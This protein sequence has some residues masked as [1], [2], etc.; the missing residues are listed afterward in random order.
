[1][2]PSKNSGRSA[3]QGILAPPT[4]SSYKKAQTPPPPSE[5]TGGSA[6]PVQKPM[7]P[8]QSQNALPQAPA[9]NLSA[10][11]TSKV[12]SPH[13]RPA[14]IHPSTTD[15]NAKRPPDS[16][17]KQP[18]PPSKSNPEDAK[19]SSKGLLAKPNESPSPEQGEGSTSQPL[20]RTHSSPPGF[21]DAKQ[22]DSGALQHQGQS[23]SQA[24]GPEAALPPPEDPKVSLADLLEH[25]FKFYDFDAKDHQLV[26]LL[27]N[28]LS[29]D[30]DVAYQSWVVF[31]KKGPV[32][33]HLTN[34]LELNRVSKRGDTAHPVSC[35]L[36]LKKSGIKLSAI[37][38]LREV[39]PD[40]LRPCS[41]LIA[42][43][44]LTAPF[45]DRVAESNFPVELFKDVSSLL[46][47]ECQR[48]ELSVD[49]ERLQAWAVEVI[50]TTWG[51]G[52]SEEKSLE[53]APYT[54]AK[55]LKAYNL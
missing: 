29:E 24:P 12:S 6:A 3:L 28:S 5:A 1:M 37:K 43:Q 38:A 32:F 13:G 35:L 46:E 11:N 51:V 31:H 52:H 45:L 50:A 44:A 9:N 2:T 15:T 30:I 42:L 10:D 54:L 49:A 7:G 53:L 18:P 4:K 40:L 48:R 25:H 39:A 17:L 34:A 16:L 22:S 8:A 41:H 20:N 47:K 21:E 26:P 36:I 19:P 23:P 33:A 55:F 14:A 27:V